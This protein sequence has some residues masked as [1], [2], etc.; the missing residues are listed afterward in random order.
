MKLKPLDGYSYVHSVKAD[1]LPGSK[2]NAACVI[3]ATTH[4]DLA[5]GTHVLV[6]MV[7]IDYRP[8]VVDKVPIFLVP[9]DAILGVLGL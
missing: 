3:V 7:N 2:P 8:L 6:D 4:S 1:E 5:P 9:N